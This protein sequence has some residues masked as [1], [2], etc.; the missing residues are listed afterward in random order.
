MKRTGVW[1]R[2]VCMVC[3]STPRTP[4]SRE[5]YRESMILVSDER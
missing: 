2:M 4:K 1:M 3:T 5:Q